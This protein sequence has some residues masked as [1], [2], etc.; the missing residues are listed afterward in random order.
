MYGDIGVKEIHFFECEED[1]SI[2]SSIQQTN[3]RQFMI[4]NDYRGMGDVQHSISAGDW[5]IGTT[6]ICF[7]ST[8][9]IEDGFKIFVHDRTGVFEIVLGEGNE[10]TNRHIRR[11]HDLFRLWCHGEFE[12]ASRKEEEE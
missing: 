12:P 3:G 11:G 1:E 9:W 6:Q 4:A 7:L 5:I 8:Q 10:R 2:W